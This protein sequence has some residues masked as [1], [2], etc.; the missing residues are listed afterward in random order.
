MA[1]CGLDQTHAH[2]AASPGFPCATRREWR[3]GVLRVSMRM[4]TIARLRR[5]G[6]G[7]LPSTQATCVAASVPFCAGLPAGPAADSWTIMAGKCPAR[8]SPQAYTS[9]KNAGCSRDPADG[10]RFAEVS[11]AWRQARPP[12]FAKGK[13]HAA[14]LRCQRKQSMREPLIRA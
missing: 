13:S 7:R 11:S 10:A 6:S 4:P 5:C 12:L 1:V 3:A 2:L 14:L 9:V 8:K